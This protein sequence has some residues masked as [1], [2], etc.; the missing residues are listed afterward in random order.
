MVS[1]KGQQQLA[2][3]P[4]Q[5]ALQARALRT[6]RALIDASVLEFSER[7]WAGTNTKTIAA[8]AGVSVGSVYTYFPNKTT[9]LREV[10]LTFIA[11]NM[12][13]AIALLPE[14][15]DIGA[16]E[17]LEHLRG[18]AAFVLSGFRRDRGLHDVLRERR[19]VDAD[20]RTLWRD[21]EERL[22]RRVAE[23]LSDI[24]VPGDTVP[25]SV[26]LFGMVDGAIEAHL[27]GNL[28]TDDQFVDALAK[29]MVAVVETSRR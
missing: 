21:Q 17:L 14:E 22:I 12:D 4:E 5:R 24:G 18:L 3:G 25:V 11:Q 23:F 20:I 2:E 27:E 19:R 26:C 16:D 8:R 29:S 10:A 1:R 13:R 9:L 28:V 7:G 15:S 6:R